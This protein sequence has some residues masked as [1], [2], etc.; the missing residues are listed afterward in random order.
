MVPMLFISGVVTLLGIILLRKDNELGPFIFGLGFCFV[1][2]FGLQSVSLVQKIN[3]VRELSKNIQ[4]LTALDAA[5]INK[6]VAHIKAHPF[7]YM[8]MDTEGID[9]ISLDSAGKFKVE[10]DGK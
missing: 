4:Y 3:S 2:F 8:M 1:L 5:D 9:Y 7:M 6:K 10:A